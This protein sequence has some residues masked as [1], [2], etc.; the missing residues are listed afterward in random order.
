MSKLEGR[1][2][3]TFVGLLPKKINN[4]TLPTTLHWLNQVV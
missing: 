2:V 1:S 3:L 4:Y